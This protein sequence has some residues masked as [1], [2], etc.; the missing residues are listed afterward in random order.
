MSLMEA[1]AGI[2]LRGKWSAAV[3][4]AFVGVLVFAPAASAGLPDSL[5]ARGSVEQVQVTG[6]NP[7]ESVKLLRRGEKVDRQPAGELG[8]IVFRRVEP[9]GGYT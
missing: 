8:G 1:K 2:G 4:A 6:A 7:G 3:L 9:G 5:D